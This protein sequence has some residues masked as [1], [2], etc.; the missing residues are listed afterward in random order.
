MNGIIGA[1]LLVAALCVATLPGC[2]WI[3]RNDPEVPVTTETYQ[4]CGHGLECRLDDQ[5]CP[6]EGTTCIDLPPTPCEVGPCIVGGKRKKP[7]RR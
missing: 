1:A 2:A 4:D 6:L 3:E 7:A 5:Q